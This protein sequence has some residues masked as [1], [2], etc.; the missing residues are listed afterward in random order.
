[1]GTFSF[2]KKLNSPIRSNEIESIIKVSIASVRSRVQTPIRGGGVGK[3]PNRT[4]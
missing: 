2:K 3:S 1:M 4:R